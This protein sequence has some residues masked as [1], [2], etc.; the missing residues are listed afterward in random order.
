MPSHLMPLRR[1][2]FGPS[3]SFPQ[4]MAVF[5]S[6]RKTH[7]QKFCLSLR[8]PLLLPHSQAPSLSPLPPSLLQDLHPLLIMLLT[9]SRDILETGPRALPPVH[10]CD[11]AKVKRVLEGKGDVV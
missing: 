1:P 2:F 9:Y 3:L 7:P 8:V 4:L 11:L 6:Q 10:Q 5:P